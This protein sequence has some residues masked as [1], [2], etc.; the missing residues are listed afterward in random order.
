MTTQTDTSQIESPRARKGG[1]L[2]SVD[3]VTSSYGP[4][5]ALRDVSIEVREGEIVALVGANGAGK[6]T[7]LLTIAGLV[8][9]SSGSI[10]LNGESILSLSPEQVV[11]HGI[12]V[13]PEGRRIF[14]HLTTS[15]NLRMGAAARRDRTAIAADLEEMFQMFP[16]L[17]DRAR[18]KAGTLSGGEQQMLALARSLMSRPRLLMLD[19]PSL[20]L[21]P[22]IVG[23]IF[24][25]VRQLPARGV[26]VLLVEQNVRAALRIADYGYVLST[27]ELVRSGYSEQLLESGDLESVY[28][29]GGAD[30]RGPSSDSP[31]TRTLNVGVVTP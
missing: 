17:R 1:L 25:F 13:A 15:E 2:L 16:I 20:G 10:K 12:S 30:D 21:A 3:G 7:L 18:Q 23:Q 9:A 22:R 19:E 27:G 4:V 29:G 11:R 14:G 6:S 31:V 26:T 5:K 8:K 28:L 24:G